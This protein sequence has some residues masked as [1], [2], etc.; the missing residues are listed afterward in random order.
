MNDTNL[1]VQSMDHRMKRLD[2]DDETLTSRIASLSKSIRVAGD[3]AREAK[4]G[5]DK[6][7]PA[8]ESIAEDLRITLTAVEKI[9]D[10]AARAAS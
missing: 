6:L 2:A 4:D 8:L 3:L 7:R 10:S 5:L 1:K 9:I